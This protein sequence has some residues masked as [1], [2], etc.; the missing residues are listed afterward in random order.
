MICIWIRVGRREDDR[1]PALENRSGEMA[2]RRTKAGTV[3]NRMI[4]DR[5]QIHCPHRE[6]W[7][8]FN[9]LKQRL[10]GVLRVRTIELTIGS[11]SNHL[12]SR[13]RGANNHSFMNMG[14]KMRPLETEV[15]IPNRAGNAHKFMRFA[16]R[17]FPG[18]L[19]QIII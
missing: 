9:E 13:T 11:A 2:A 5:K 12:D 17:I 10:R 16:G 3:R 7:R 18:A 14:A 19:N 8:R 15:G 6:I 1:P 4:R